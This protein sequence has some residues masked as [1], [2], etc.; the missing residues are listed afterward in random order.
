MLIEN[1]RKSEPGRET[2]LDEIDVINSVKE[3]WTIGEVSRAYRLSLRALRFYE[4][5]GMLQP[6]RRGVTR[7]YDSRARARLELILKG[8]HLGFTLSEIA[9]LIEKS[10]RQPQDGIKLA[11]A[12]AQVLEQIETLERQRA[13]LEAAIAEL[14][15]THAR[16]AA[17]D[18]AQAQAAV[19]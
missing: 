4:E 17:L 10:E 3:F 14:R 7:L 2:H 5:R 8:K 18:H 11:L 16:L 9:D 1:A 19:A 13:E 15:E 6:F 12:P